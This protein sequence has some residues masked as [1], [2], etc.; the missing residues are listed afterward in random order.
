MSRILA[1]GTLLA[2]LA[3]AP[4]ASGQEPSGKDKRAAKE[5]S[6]SA[7]LTQFNQ[8]WIQAWLDKDPATVERLMAD[9]YVYVTPTGLAQDRAAI[10]HIIRSPGYRLRRWNQSNL[11]VRMLGDN[12]AVIRLRG[13]GEGEFEDKPFKQDQACMRVCARVRGEWQVVAEQCTDIKP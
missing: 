5:H 9:D 13:Q 2:L 11:V 12:A 7:E 3:A 8:R 6:M 1:G 10:L 4:W